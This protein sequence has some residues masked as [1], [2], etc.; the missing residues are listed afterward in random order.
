MAKFQFIYALQTYG[1]RDFKLTVGGMTGS[2]GGGG[3]TNDTYAVFL[4]RDP[5]LPGFLDPP[6]GGTLP[7]NALHSPS[8]SIA[9]TANA[10]A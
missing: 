9:S 1:G 6:L 2:R 8:L 4:V 7:H 5:P 3:V 10:Y